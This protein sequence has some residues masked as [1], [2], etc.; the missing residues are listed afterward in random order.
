MDGVELV[1][2]RF[3]VILGLKCPCLPQMGRP[4]LGL[5]VLSAGDRQ[6]VEKYRGG[7][8]NQW[9]HDLSRHGCGKR[10]Q[11]CSLARASGT[12]R[13]R[14]ASS[15]HS[16][17]LARGTPKAIKISPGGATRKD[18]RGPATHTAAQ[19]RGGPGGETG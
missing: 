11:D 14:R 7:R 3:Q 4:R 5:D 10:C 18:R 15:P 19:P 12:P 9:S 17:K 2:E 6:E 13:W 8:A 16:P 1:R